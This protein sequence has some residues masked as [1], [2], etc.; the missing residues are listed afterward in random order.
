MIRMV[1]DRADRPTV[2]VVGVG[3][4][5][6]KVL[7][8]LIEMGVNGMGSVSIATDSATFERS[9]AVERL[10]VGREIACRRG[11]EGDPDLGRRAVLQDIDLVREA[12]EEY[13]TVVLVGGLGGGTAAGALPEIASLAAGHGKRVLA[14][15]TRPLPYE[16]RRRREVAERALAALRGAACGVVSVPNEALLSSIEKE[17]SI[18]DAFF[19]RVNENVC[20]AVRSL[21]R[22]LAG[23]GI[24]NADFADVLSVLSLAGDA[25]IGRGSGEG[26]SRA[27]DAAS[28]ALESPMLRNAPLGAAAAMLLSFEG[29]RDVAFHDIKQALERVSGSAAAGADIITCA[30]ADEEMGD[31]Y[32]ATIIAVGLGI[33]TAPEKAAV[34]AKETSRTSRAV[35]AEQIFIDFSAPERGRFADLE[36]SIYDGEDLDIPTILR[37]RM[38]LEPASAPL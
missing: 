3:G 22:L 16:G 30:F 26:S 15:V 6:S 25:A 28:E 5:G 21:V 17:T 31:R 23:G 18:A 19:D 10:L 33:E 8:K 4:A 35:K 27:L 36:P 1:D 38:R 11:C 34:A 20:H 24:I 9:V 14:V 32:T 37:R 29:S 12:I 13:G 2:A 7:N